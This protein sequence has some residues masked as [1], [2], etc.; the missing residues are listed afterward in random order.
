MQPGD[1]GV[2]VGVDVAKVEHYAHAMTV[3]G[4]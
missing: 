3:S 1:V 2:F 4:T